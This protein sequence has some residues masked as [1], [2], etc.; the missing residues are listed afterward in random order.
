MNIVFEVKKTLQNATYHVRT[1]TGNIP[2]RKN[3]FFDMVLFL[4]FGIF[5]LNFFFFVIDI[6][7][8]V[9]VGWSA[10]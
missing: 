8:F 3:P 5:E 10:I 7:F 2:I 4:Q 6:K 1:R 9:I